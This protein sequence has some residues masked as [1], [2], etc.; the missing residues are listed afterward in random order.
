MDDA[1]IHARIEQ[2]VTDEQALHERHV[3]ES[4]SP[5]ERVRLEETTVQLDRLWDLLRQRRARR[6]AGLDP[7]DASLRGGDT[8]EEY[9]Q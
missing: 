2:L 1:Q 4:L 8:V 6:E 9:L 3:G 7:N 5:D